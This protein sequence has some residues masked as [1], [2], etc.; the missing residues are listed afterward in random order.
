MAKEMRGKINPNH[1]K[2]AAL[3]LVDGL[4]ESR[5][6]GTLSARHRRQQDNWESAGI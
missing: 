4:G 6:K 5:E 1:V 2:G 3:R